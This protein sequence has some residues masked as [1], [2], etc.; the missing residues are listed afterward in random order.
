MG[1]TAKRIF[2]L[3]HENGKI[4]GQANL[5]N[6]VTR[7]YKGLFGEPKQ[8]SFSLDPDRTEDIAQVTQEENNFLTAPFTEDE[9]KKAIFKME[10][11]KAPRLDGFLAKFYQKFWHVIK[12]DLI[13]MFQ[14]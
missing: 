11:N 14:D 8:N 4:E 5:K 3:D 12:G 7:F 10:H 9:I 2:S 1:T 13:T 6:Y